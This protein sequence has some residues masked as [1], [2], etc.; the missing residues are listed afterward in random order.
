MMVNEGRKCYITHQLF[1]GFMNLEQ[2]HFERLDF[3][4]LRWHEGQTVR[5]DDGSNFCLLVIDD[6]IGDFVGMGLAIEK[7]F[8]KSRVGIVSIL[9]HITDI[10]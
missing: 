5:A 3:F 1:A 8:G 4:T 10:L 2:S 9:L 7:E 6:H